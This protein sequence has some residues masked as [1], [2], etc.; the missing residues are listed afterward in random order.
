MGD[1]NAAKGIVN[2]L[3]LS[4]IFYLIVYAIYRIIKEVLM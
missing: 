1:L 3:G 2:G 4:F